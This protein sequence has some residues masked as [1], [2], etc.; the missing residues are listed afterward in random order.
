[1]E[2]NTRRPFFNI[3]SIFTKKDDSQNIYIFKK[4]SIYVTYSVS[5]CGEGSSCPVWR[6]M[7]RLL[8]FGPYYP[9]KTSRICLMFYQM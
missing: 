8:N 7:E 5:S 2:V 3:R 9:I 1:M 4:L 6:W